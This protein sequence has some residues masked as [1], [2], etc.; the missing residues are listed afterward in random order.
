MMINDLPD[1]ILEKISFEVKYMEKQK[2]YDKCKRWLINDISKLIDIG[3]WIEVEKSFR[4]IN[5]GYGKQKQYKKFNK[6]INE[7]NAI[8]S[9]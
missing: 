3:Y 5:D 6:V 2:Y 4:N 7:L 1:S 9:E 8:F